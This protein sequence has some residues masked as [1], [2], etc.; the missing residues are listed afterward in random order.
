MTSVNIR[1]LR[2]S[3]DRLRRQ[4]SAVEISYDATALAIS[5]RLFQSQ[6]VLF[7]NNDLCAP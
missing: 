1:L 6:L 7:P 4:E 3:P 5:A 2:R